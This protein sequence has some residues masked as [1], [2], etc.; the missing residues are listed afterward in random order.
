MKKSSL[1]R[2]RSS[3]N[4]LPPSVRDAVLQATPTDAIGCAPE[5][6]KALTA[7]CLGLMGQTLCGDAF[8]LA[9]QS[10]EQLAL[11]NGVPPGEWKRVGKIVLKYWKQERAKNPLVGLF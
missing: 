5:A 11:Q 4:S 10:A 7:L 3:G 2:T 9:V 8:F 1:V 6:V